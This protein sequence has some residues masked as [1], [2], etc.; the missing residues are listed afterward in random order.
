MDGWM[1]GMYCCC[2]WE[3]RIQRGSVGG[4]GCGSVDDEK[5]PALLYR[6][7]CEGEWVG[8]TCRSV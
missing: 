4:G 8:E 6:R 3:S 5:L 2:V 1:D 7:G